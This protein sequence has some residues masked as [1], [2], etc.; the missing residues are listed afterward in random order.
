MLADAPGIQDSGVVR[1]RALLVA[2]R[3]DLAADVRDLSQDVRRKTHGKGT[4]PDRSAPIERIRRKLEVLRTS[5]ESTTVAGSGVTARDLTARALRENEQALGKLIQGYATPDQASAHA[6]IAESVRLTAQSK[7]TSV[8]A[9]QA[10][11]IA[12]PLP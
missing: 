6:L 2:A 12:W 10:L 5:V 7:A 3:A 9:G 1:I 4:V 8:R 11:G